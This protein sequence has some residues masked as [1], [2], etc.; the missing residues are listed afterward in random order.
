MADYIML[1]KGRNAL[2]S[3]V[4]ACLNVALAI[5]CT[6]LTVISGNW[7]FGVLLVLLS[8]WRVV[9]V[10][11]RYWI[12]NI[13]SNLVDLVVGISIVML[14]YMAGTDG[15]NAWHIILTVIYIIWLGGIKPRSETIAYLWCCRL[16][17]DWLWRL[18]S[19]SNAGGRARLYAH[20]LHFWHYASRVVLDLL[21]LV[22]RLYHQQSWCYNCYTATTDCCY[23]DVLRV[24]ARL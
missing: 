16:F 24:G 23:Y 22:N 14:V 6:A 19:R 18:S 4:H 20:Y 13:K 2:S 15:L 9:A 5:L 12:L 7:I 10:R 21:S 17:L 3:V 8:K 1:R 11:P